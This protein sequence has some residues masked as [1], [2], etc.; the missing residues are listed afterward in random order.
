VSGRRLIR[1]TLW[2][3]IVV[4]RAA[5]TA[6]VAFAVACLVTAATDEGGVGWLERA[7][8]TLPVIPLCAALG[9][10]AALAP[11]LARGEALALEALG[12]SPAQIGIAAITGAALV[13]LIVS[14]FL[15]ASRSIDVAGFYPLVHHASSWHW[16]GGDFVDESRGLR[17]LA[18]GAP[19]RSPPAGGARA[20]SVSVPPHGRAAAGLALAGAGMAL[21]VLVAQT[22][23]TGAG[24]RKGRGLPPGLRAVIAAG[25]SVVASVALFQAAAVRYVPAVA[26]ALPPLLLLAFALLRYREAGDA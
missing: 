5:A 1:P 4:A 25:V 24:P 17:V 20:P 10:W 26:G 23:L 13:A 3:A 11:V 22:L 21:P 9:A 14:V 12:R 2:D 18:D 7:S 8:R 15:G 19:V 6:L 16:D